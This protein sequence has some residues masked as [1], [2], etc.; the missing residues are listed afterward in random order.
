MSSDSGNY[1]GFGYPDIRVP[2]EITRFYGSHVYLNLILAVR[3]LRINPSF[4]QQ[5]CEDVENDFHLNISDV[6][7]E[8]DNTCVK[9]LKHCDIVCK[10]MKLANPME[11]NVSGLDAYVLMYSELLGV[12][13]S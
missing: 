3:V 1:S 9:V 4:F 10:L 12:I 5:Q 2:V 13:I 11:F 6:L 7:L 8:L